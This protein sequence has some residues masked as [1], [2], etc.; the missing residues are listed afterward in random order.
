MRCH[1]L[2]GSSN[3]A[4]VGWTYIH[5]GVTVRFGFDAIRTSQLPNVCQEQ[6]NGDAPWDVSYIQSLLAHS[7]LQ[8]VNR[9]YYI[10]TSAWGFQ[11]CSFRQTGQCEGLN[12]VERATDWL[13][14]FC[15]YSTLIIIWQ[16]GSL[17]HKIGKA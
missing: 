15:I 7:I 9:W 10:L 8:W 12:S 2:T 11:R 6:S 1:I 14:A 16:V 3:W 13:R 4:K 17:C 5:K